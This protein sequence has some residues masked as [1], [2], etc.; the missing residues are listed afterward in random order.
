MSTV[1]VDPSLPEFGAPTAEAIVATARVVVTSAS[2]VALLA[3]HGI[4]NAIAITAPLGPT[5]VQELVDRGAHT[6]H[7]IID[8]TPLAEFISNDGIATAL[9][10]ELDVQ[11]IESY[12]SSH[13]FARAVADGIYAMPGDLESAAFGGR[14]VLE[15][16]CSYGWKCIAGKS[17]V[18]RSRLVEKIAAPL[19]RCVND[20]ARER[21]VDLLAESLEL[22][23]RGV[24][25]T[26]KA[27]IN[28]IVAAEARAAAARDPA[29]F[30]EQ[31]QAV[32]PRIAAEEA[33]GR[34]RVH[35][36][37]G[38][39]MH[40]AVDRYARIVA[41]VGALSTMYGTRSR[42]AKVG[43]ALV[44]E[45]HQDFDYFAAEA[46]PTTAAEAVA[47]LRETAQEAVAFYQRLDAAEPD[48][49]WASSTQGW[50][51]LIDTLNGAIKHADKRRRRA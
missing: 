39:A 33:G 8:R 2:N 41:T 5:A 35:G 24:A 50:Q 44:Q 9:R 47:L 43:R 7:L 18:D 23:R 42:V 19:L 17:T 28:A 10:R 29:G 12:A 22:P 40:A 49:G 11:I 4:V 46:V 31:A 37:A 3:A 27:A 25:S 51:A 6:A 15:W 1:P 30:G 26:I 21:L 20:A 45:A 48:V 16:L 14:E 32:E 38:D 34:P 36:F 13:T